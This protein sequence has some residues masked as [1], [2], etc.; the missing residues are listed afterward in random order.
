VVGQV[1]SSGQPI[2]KF[3]TAGG[4]GRGAPLQLGG[5]T[6]LLLGFPVEITEVLPSSTAVSTAFWCFGSLY[7]SWML[8]QRRGVEIAQS[9]EV[10]FASDQVAIRGIERIDIVPGDATGMVKTTTAAS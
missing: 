2:V 3:V 1:D 8:G 5:A 6:P 7:M 10:Y 4:E 9:R